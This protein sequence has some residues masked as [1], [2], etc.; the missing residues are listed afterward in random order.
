M[1]VGQGGGTTR[2]TRGYGAV[3][4]EVDSSSSW[5]QS[6]VS[7][8]RPPT[9]AA[10]RVQQVALVRRFGRWFLGRLVR[11]WLVR[12]SWGRLGDRRVRRWRARRSRRDR[13]G[14]HRCHRYGARRGAWWRGGWR[15]GWH[16]RRCRW[17]WRSW[18]KGRNRGRVPARG[19][20]GRPPSRCRCGR[21]PSMSAP[22]TGSSSSGCSSGSP[23]PGPPGCRG[24]GS[25]RT[26][27][28]PRPGMRRTRSAGPTSRRRCRPTPTAPRCPG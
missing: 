9:M 11:G 5:T 10:H 27:T 20:G 15:H 26:G 12:R 25:R 4:S 16:L 13:R 23:R 22:G 14:R 28:S 18:R 3:G 8:S 21:P 17:R 7:P 2:G 24:R 6:G 1:S 19:R